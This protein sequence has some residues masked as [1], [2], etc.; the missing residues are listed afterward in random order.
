MSWERG[1]EIMVGWLSERDPKSYR[2]RYMY[3]VV[4][5]TY[6][7]TSVALCVVPFSPSHRLCQP[8][9]LARDRKIEQSQQTWGGLHA[10]TSRV[11]RKGPGHLRRT[12]SSR[13]TSTRMAPAA[14]GSLS[15][16]KLVT[17]NAMQAELHACISFTLL[18]RPEQRNSYMRQQSIYLNK[19]HRRSQEVR[20]ELQAAVAQLSEAKHKARWLLWRRGQ[21][22]LQPLR[23]HRQQVR[24]Q[25]KIVWIAYIKLSIHL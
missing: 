22:H 1:D 10:A 9:D 5:N 21:D 12:A 8:R 6:S 15:L 17:H 2:V 14:T 3:A 11:W 23:Y 24:D 18:A 7:T 25:L 20:Q 13:S 19:L 16:T 4:P